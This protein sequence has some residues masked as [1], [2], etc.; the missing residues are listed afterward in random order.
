MALVEYMGCGGPVLLQRD[1]S[2]KLARIQQDTLLVWGEQDEILD[3]RCAHVVA[4]AEQLTPSAG[5]I[6]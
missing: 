1:V 5:E 6:P 4:P 3:K 2:D